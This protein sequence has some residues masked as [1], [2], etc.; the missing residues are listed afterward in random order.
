PRLPPPRHGRA[1]AGRGH[2][3]W[4]LGQERPL[5]AGR[6][7]Q[8]ERRHRRRPRLL[9][10]AAP[11]LLPRGRVSTGIPARGGHPQAGQSA[12]VM[13][14]T[15]SKQ[16]TILV[17]GL[18]LL[19]LAA[20][21]PGR[22]TSRDSALGVNGEV[23]QVKAGN[24]GDLF[25]NGHA[26]DPAVPVLA[27]DVTQPGAAPQR[28]LIP[29]TLDP[30]AETSASLIYENDSQT[31]YALWASQVGLNPVLKLSGYDGTSWST[32]IQVVGNP[33]ATKGS[34]QFTMTRETFQ[35]IADDGTTATKHRTTLHL[36][37]QEEV[38]PGAP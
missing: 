12:R 5:P 37:W 9:Q 30:A 36:L 14:S 10:P 21:L 4:P 20:A 28:I 32:P 19:G 23:Y 31:V 1:G 3:G 6:G 8:P 29:D 22:A 24:Y 27:I 18:A 25:P 11:G 33:Y 34:P 38:V 2:R 16:R 17:L 35:D 13:R 26:V 7:R 15:M